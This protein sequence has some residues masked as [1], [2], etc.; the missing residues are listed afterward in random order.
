[1]SEE[2]DMLIEIATDH[3]FGYNSIYAGL[4]LPATK[5][6]IEDSVQQARA[7]R[8]EAAADIRVHNCTGLPELTDT[9]LECPTLDELN[10]FA[11]RLTILSEKETLALNAIFLQRKENGDYDEVGVSMKDLI[12]LTYGLSD[13]PVVGGLDTDEKLGE[14]VLENDMDETLKYV[15]KEL[16]PLLDKAKIGKDFR[17]TEDGVFFEGCYVSAGGYIEQSVYDGENLPEEMPIEYGDG[18]IHLLVGKPATPSTTDSIEDTIWISLPIQKE[19]ANEVANKLGARR[20]EDCVYFDM[21]S[22]IPYINE[23]AFDDTEK[24]DKLNE[25]AEMY[26]SMNNVNR[27]KYKAIMESIGTD[28]LDKALEVIDS[29]SE[30]E[31]SYYSNHTENYGAEYL[32][33]VLP[34]NADMDLFSSEV[35]QSIGKSLLNKMSATMTEYGV[36]SQ[37]GKGLFPTNQNEEQNLDE[38]QSVGG[39]QM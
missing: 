14:F 28:D 19:M 9:R 38:E 15:N 35:R 34:S 30:Y 4:F 7:V 11:Y 39:L 17:E 1:M 16:I 32:T 26:L 13:I 29:M 21:K 3:P 33:H 23:Q 36:I 22:A 6:Q 18:I 31:F 20:I 8:R 25:L 10:F 12:N 24:F 37:R 5:S 27:V 2:R